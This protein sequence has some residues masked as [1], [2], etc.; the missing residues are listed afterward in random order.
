MTQVQELV[1][2]LFQLHD[3]HMG[4]FETLVILAAATVPYDSQAFSVLL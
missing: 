3:V 2:Y 1:L 4:P